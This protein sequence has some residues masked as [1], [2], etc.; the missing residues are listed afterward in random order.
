M[1]AP[2]VLVGAGHLSTTAGGQAK[3]CVM[4]T[5]LAAIRLIPGAAGQNPVWLNQL[6]NEADAAIKSWCKRDLEFTSYPGCAT[7]G[8]G[9]TGYYSGLNEATI[10]L[11]QYP[12]ALPQTT[13]A[14][15]SN[16]ADVS[17]TTVN[18]G[19]TT[20]FPSTG[21][22]TVILS[23][24]NPSAAAITYTGKTATTFT[25]CTTQSTGTLATD[26]Q[27][28]G[29][30]VWFNQAGFGGQAPNAFANQTLLTIGQSYMIPTRRV[31]GGTA[32]DMSGLLTMIG[33]QALWGGTG[34]GGNW[35]GYQNN[36]LSANRLPSW[37]QG[38]QNVRIAYAAGYPT[39]PPDLAYA[40]QLLVEFMIKNLPYGGLLQS[41]HIGSY[42]Y[43][44]IYGGAKGQ[45]PQLGT[46]ATTLS[47]YRDW[48]GGGN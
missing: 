43:S 1:H 9:D 45:I 42:A 5:T 17:A 25:G 15:G 39:I 34:W 22:F 46:L 2:A 18:V 8:V 47:L 28:W 26:Q 11:R 7:N 33:G 13:I 41:E 36:K 10:N 44:L 23:T 40:C 4:L 48:A 30:A 6:L 12:V 20:G 35:A 21:T 14:A 31:V 3:G 37:P 29:V 19:S 32:A 16:G 24:P 27:V 38:Y